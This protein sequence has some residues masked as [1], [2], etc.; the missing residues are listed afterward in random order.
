MVSEMTITFAPKAGLLARITMDS[1]PTTQQQY[2]HP[3]KRLPGVRL[4]NL[5]I[6]M[7]LSAIL[8]KKCATYITYSTTD[9]Y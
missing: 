8:T 4:Q 7:S 9:I 6:Y 3:V 1:T 5:S 2:V